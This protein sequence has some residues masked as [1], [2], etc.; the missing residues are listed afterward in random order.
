MEDSERICLLKSMAM[1]HSTLG[2][3]MKYMEIEIKVKVG[4]IFLV[5]L[6]LNL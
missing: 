1:K 6:K 5:S 2:K 3:Q 4:S